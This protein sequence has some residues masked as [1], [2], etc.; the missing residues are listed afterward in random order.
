MA[1]TVGFVWMLKILVY[2]FWYLDICRVWCAMSLFHRGHG[3]G[4]RR[5]RAEA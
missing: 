2:N 3:L 5:V 4:L 1:P